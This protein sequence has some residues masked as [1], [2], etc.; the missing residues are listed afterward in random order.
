MAPTHR[1]AEEADDGRGRTR[2]TDASIGRFPHRHLFHF[3]FSAAPLSF[4]PMIRGI[5][6]RR[7]DAKLWRDGVDVGRQAGAALE[8]NVGK[9]ARP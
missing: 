9:V 4:D 6:R 1:A 8:L 5:K 7:M 3:L 2:R